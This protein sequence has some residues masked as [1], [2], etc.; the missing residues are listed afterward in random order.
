[1][2]N[3]PRQKH[4]GIVGGGYRR[5]HGGPIVWPSAATGSRCGSGRRSS[6]ARP[7]RSRSPGNYLEYFYHHLFQS[8][9][10]IVALIEELGIGD[11]LLWLPSNVG[12]FADGKIY[13]LNGALGSAQ[14]GNHPDSRPVAPRSRHRIPPAGQGLEEVREGHGRKMAETG[15]RR[16]SLR[17]DPRRAA[18]RQVRQVPARRR[19]GLV[20]GQ[21]LAAH[22]IA[23]FASRS[24]KARL[25]QGQL[26]CR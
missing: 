23:P 15:A 16:A 21:D 2:S 14:A 3:E 10:E 22:D 17:A 8:D 6:V 25:H 26:Q 13:P 24:G 20:L 5:T 9:R 19:D 4:I 12:Y 11:K 7:S 18:R 1:M